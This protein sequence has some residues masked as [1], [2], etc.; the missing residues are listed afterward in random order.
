MW[1]FLSNAVSTTIRL[2]SLNYFNIYPNS[3]HFFYH[4]TW[5]FTLPTPAGMY[6]SLYLDITNVLVDRRYTSLV[7]D[8]IVSFKYEYALLLK[9]WFLK[10]D[11]GLKTKS[12]KS[13]EINLRFGY[14]NEKVMFWRNLSEWGRAL[15]IKDE[16]EHY[17][18]LS[19]SVVER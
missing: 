18:I 2:T 16:I 10:K 14:E 3:V 4:A 12:I 13:L 8:W 9:F 19:L 17:K 11:V 7:K 15:S 6:V 1:T 5:W